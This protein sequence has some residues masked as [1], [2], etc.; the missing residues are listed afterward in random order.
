MGLHMSTGFDKRDHFVHFEMCVFQR[1]NFHNGTKFN[2][3]RSQWGITAAGRWKK[4]FGRY[5]E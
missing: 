1:S 4:A 2:V 3:G 5:H